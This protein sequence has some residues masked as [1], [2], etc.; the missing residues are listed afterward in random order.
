MVA[1]IRFCR[2][3]VI[4]EST[5]TYLVDIWSSHIDLMRK[6]VNWIDFCVSMSSEN[7]TRS[8]PRV[9]NAYNNRNHMYSTLIAIIRPWEI[10]ESILQKILT[11]CIDRSFA[12]D[13]SMS[14]LFLTNN[15]DERICFISWYEE[16]KHYNQTFTLK[17][18]RITIKYMSFPPSQA[19]L[20]SYFAHV[21]T[22]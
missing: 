3:V 5:R 19:C 13:Q 9:E 7:K 1:M 6:A 15:S 14:N 4:Y 17:N 22:H 12:F 8:Y 10:V 20:S 16:K 11:E 21:H 18:D 2:H